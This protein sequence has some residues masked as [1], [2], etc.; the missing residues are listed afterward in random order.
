MFGCA[1]EAVCREL[2]SRFPPV[3]HPRGAKIVAAGAPVAGLHVLL[4]GTVSVYRPAAPGRELLVKLLRAPCSFGEIGLLHGLPFLED[5]EAADDAAIAQI[6]AEDYFALLA[7]HPVV[8]MEQLRH[9]TGALAVAHKNEQQQLVALDQ[10]VANLLLCYGDLFGRADAAGQVALD[11]EVTQPQI[12]R[13]LGVTTR[14]VA[15]ILARWRRDRLVT[16]EGARLVLRD[17]QALEAM[18]RPIRGS[19]CF[20]TGMPLRCHEPPAESALRASLSVLRGPRAC[21]GRQ[22]VIADEAVVGRAP[23][24]QLPLPDETI[25]PRHCRIYLSSSGGRFWAEDLGTIN[26]TY[27]NERRIAQRCVLRDG[28]TIQL[29]RS[30]MRFLLGA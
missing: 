7:A 23:D 1:G 6:A 17:P 25:D 10:R 30:V 15:N 29:G 24:C 14:G 28:D 8:L 3:V 4:D 20:R 22:A 27:V 12:A 2:A 26:G 11:A 21:V 13:A 16:R 19:L 18:A 5:V 9:V